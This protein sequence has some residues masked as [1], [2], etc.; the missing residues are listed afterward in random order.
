MII[1]HIPQAQ[2]G[3]DDAVERGLEM[4]GLTAEAYAKLELSTPKP[5]ADGT[6]KPNIDTGRLLNSISHITA[7]DGL[8]LSAYIGTNVEYAPY[9]ELGTSK[10]QAYPYLRPAVEKHIDEYKQI[11]E[12]ALKGTI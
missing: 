2:Q 5:H 3:I 4:I 6:M 10:M 12:A 1:S 9:V 8:G 7:D 11:L